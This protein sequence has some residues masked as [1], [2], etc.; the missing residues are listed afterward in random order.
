M[1][2]DVTSVTTTLSNLNDITINIAANEKWVIQYNLHAQSPTAADFKFAV[3]APAGATCKFS[4]YDAEGATA[5]AN[6]GCGVATGL[7]A[8][9]GLD[10]P[11]QAFATVVNGATAGQV[12]LQWSQ[13]VVSGTSI[14]RAG[15]TV[16]AYK[17]TGADLAEIYYTSD[18]TVQEGDIVSLA[19]NGVSQVQKS[20]KAYDGR[21]L[22]IISTKP[23][24]VIG[25]ADGT[26]KPVIV[27]LSGRV[28]VKVSTKNGD[29][30]PG[31]YITTS[32]IPGV[33][34]RATRAGHTI[35]KAL[36]GLA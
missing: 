22:G 30:H 29:I 33:G 20:S 18:A 4:V 32:D 3:T 9:S 21:S 13:F 10:D 23:G 17:V 2:A 26:G 36:T 16:L 8:G 11:Y 7:I 34:M 24:I 14:V 1:L 19:G 31:D 25:A 6:L 5:Q 12:T 28:P 15:S 35:G 27:G